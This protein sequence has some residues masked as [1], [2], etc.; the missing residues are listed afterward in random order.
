MP[1]P[2]GNFML[3]QTFLMKYK[4]WIKRSFRIC[5]FFWRMKKKVEKNRKMVWRSLNRVWHGLRFGSRRR[6]V[7][8][9]WNNLWI[10]NFFCFFW[11]K[12]VWFLIFELSQYEAVWNLIRDLNNEVNFET[13]SFWISFVYF[14]R[15]KWLIFHR[16]F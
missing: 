8:F 5:F 12:E 10:L 1:C 11:K 14:R 2:N 13:C 3:G 15:K 6:M 16:E 4:L 9:R 7:N